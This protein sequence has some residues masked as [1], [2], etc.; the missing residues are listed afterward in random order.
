M[1]FEPLQKEPQYVLLISLESNMGSASVGVSSP[2]SSSSTRVR[3]PP[4]H[5]TR[6]RSAPKVPAASDKTMLLSAPRPN[7]PHVY[8]L[9]LLMML[10]CATSSVAS[11]TYARKSAAVETAAT[12]EA[13]LSSSCSVAT[14]CSPHSH[15]QRRT[16]CLLPVSVPHCARRDSLSCPSRRHLRATPTRDRQW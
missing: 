7:W 12:D 5:P 10:R 15:L 6:T 3:P 9:A 14:R 2:H 1:L 13:M 8:S 11:A 16:R 4:S